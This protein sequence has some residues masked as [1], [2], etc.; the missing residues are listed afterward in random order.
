M[1]YIKEYFV[2][3]GIDNVLTFVN[4]CVDWIGQYPPEAYF[5]VILLSA[6]A[7]GIIAPFVLVIWHWDRVEE[8]YENRGLPKEPE[9]LNWYQRRYHNV[10]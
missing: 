4:L 8:A 3:I 6:A 5:A 2:N 10:Q 9:E 1:P 7:Y